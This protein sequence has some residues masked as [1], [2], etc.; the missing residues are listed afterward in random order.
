MI[1]NLNNSTRKN[2]RFVAIVITKDGS[3]I[4][5]FG[6]RGGNTYID[7]ATEEERKNYR[8][9]HYN[10]VKEN[11]LIRELI[12]SP[13]LLS[14]FLLWGNSRNLKK[15]VEHLNQLWKK[16]YRHVLD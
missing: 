2:K 12:P 9:R 3:Q 6:L 15:N 16:K 14:Y 8:L 1:I 7:T 10:N 11:M 4:I 5:H 13:S